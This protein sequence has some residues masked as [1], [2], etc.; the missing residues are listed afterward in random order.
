MGTSACL[1]QRD[2]PVHL[3]PSPAEPAGGAGN[4]FGF[5]KVRKEDN[6]MNLRRLPDIADPLMLGLVFL[7]MVT[8]LASLVPNIWIGYFAVATVATLIAMGLRN[9]SYGA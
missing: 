3:T 4:T 2:S 1:A 6:P 9:S 5:W 7:I 8:I